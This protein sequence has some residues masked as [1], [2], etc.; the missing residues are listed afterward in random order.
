M[1]GEGLRGGADAIRRLHH[2]SKDI[3]ISRYG[4]AR[5]RDQRTELMHTSHH[6]KATDR[7]RSKEDTERR[8]RSKVII[9]PQLNSSLGESLRVCFRGFPQGQVL[10]VV[11]RPS[12][13]VS[14]CLQPRATRRA[15][16]SPATGTGIRSRRPGQLHLPVFEL[17]RKEK[18]A[19]D[20][21]QLLWPERAAPRLHQRREEHV[22]IPQPAFRLQEG[23]HGAPHG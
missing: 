21:H 15:A 18:G 10:I 20:R 9:P 13:R 6:S 1:E 17:H 3:I 5:H 7:R 16:S 12:Q 4:R 11:C 19:S 8:L 14:E 2:H 22:W 23:G